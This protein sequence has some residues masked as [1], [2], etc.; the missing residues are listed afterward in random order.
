MV[1][2]VTFNPAVDYIVHTKQLIAG[3]TNRSDSEESTSAERA[4]RFDSPQRAWS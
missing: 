3:A 1:Y 2:T 4:Q